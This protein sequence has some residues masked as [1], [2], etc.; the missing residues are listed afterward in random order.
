VTS[1]GGVDLVP[2][3]ALQHPRNR[4][5][6]S[7][8][9]TQTPEHLWQTWDSA[10]VLYYFERNTSQRGVSC[11]RKFR[12][13][14]RGGT[15]WANGLRQ[16][17]EIVRSGC[18]GNGPSLSCPFLTTVAETSGPIDF[19]QRSCCMEDSTSSKYRPFPRGSRR[20]TAVRDRLRLGGKY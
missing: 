14:A 9:L 3:G 7:E 17:F 8:D 11:G 10:T 4:R 15:R 12:Q 6:L 5:S 16:D 19:L 2:S 13:H 1:T 20:D 18:Y